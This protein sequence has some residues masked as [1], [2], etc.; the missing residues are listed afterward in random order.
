MG[1]GLQDDMYL[2]GLI[3]TFR[4]YCAVR[5]EGE[6]IPTVRCR[7]CPWRSHVAHSQCTSSSKCGAVSVPALPAS[8]GPLLLQWALSSWSG[9]PTSFTRWHSTLSSPPSPATHPAPYPPCPPR[10]TPQTGNSGIYTVNG[11]DVNLLLCGG[12]AQPVAGGP[13]P[14]TP[15][16]VN[17]T[18][19][20]STRVRVTNPQGNQQLRNTVFWTENSQIPMPN[21]TAIVPDTQAEF[22][23]VAT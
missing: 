15:N 23:T 13:P 8:H 19:T 11:Q 21:F 17:M 6:L 14:G 12:F 3:C 1:G 10:L 4:A 20:Q 22:Y 16:L 18:W 5:Q 2:Q 7:C 9:H